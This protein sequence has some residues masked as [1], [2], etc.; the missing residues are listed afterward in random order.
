MDPYLNDWLDLL[1]RWLHV[2]AGIVWIGTSFYFVALDNHLRPPKD[3]RR[4][5]EGVGGET[6]EVHGGGFYRIEKYRVAPARLPDPLHWFKWEAYTTWL[7][8]FALLIV[9]YYVDADVNLVDRRVADLSEGEAIAISIG[10]LVGAWVV[11]D[12]LCRLLA[13]RPVVLATAL[14]AAIAAGSY[15]AHELLSARAAFLQVGAML[16]TV[17]VANVLLVII[18]GHW[19]L[20]RAKEAGREPDP[21]HGLF[22]KQRSV[23]NNY[24]TLG[25][26]FTMISNHFPV[27]YGHEH[28]WAVLVALIAL[29]AWI[30]LFFNLR[31]DGQTH[32]SILASAGAAMLALALAIEPEDE[33]RGTAP[34]VGFNRIQQIVVERCAPCHSQE[35]TNPAVTA[36]P[37]GVELD[38]P[39]EIAAQAEA[40]ERQAVLSRAMPPGNVTGMTDHER[41]LLAA[42]IAAGAPAR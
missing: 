29:G 10:L 40:I 13:G 36:P 14:L 20:I 17:M 24:L 32:Y 6:W 16:G 12:G 22:G 30:R 35:P 21:R 5:E 26:V 28:S 42:W 2:M 39:D 33:R 34:L 25:V 41:D 4:Q 1:F 11:Y 7:S 15:A 18:P 9:V 37:Q 3:R 38:S 23:H 8:G 27:L 19:E 31:H